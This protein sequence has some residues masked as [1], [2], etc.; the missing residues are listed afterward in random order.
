MGFGANIW[1]ETGHGEGRL[2]GFGGGGE[3]RQEQKQK[4]FFWV[5]FG[6]LVER[7]GRS[8]PRKPGIEEAVRQVWGR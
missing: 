8:A 3:D 4:R 2:G 6:C 1:S 7:R 5:Y